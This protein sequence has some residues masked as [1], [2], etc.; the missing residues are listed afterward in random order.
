[1]Y[2]TSRYFLAFF[3]LFIIV[4]PEARDTGWY[5]VKW[6]GST[7]CILVPTSMVEFCTKPSNW[8][9]STLV[10]YGVPRTRCLGSILQSVV[11]SKGSQHG[12]IQVSCLNIF[13]SRFSITLVLLSIFS[14]S[15][16]ERRT[17]CQLYRFVHHYS[18]VLRICLIAEHLRMGHHPKMG[19]SHLVLA[20][21]LAYSKSSC[22]FKCQD[23]VGVTHQYW[24]LVQCMSRLVR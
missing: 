4:L 19:P 20:S 3:F 21:R 2:P 16:M 24:Y 11:I 22:I 5:Q 7:L 1:M 17:W 18:S 13:L 9:C 14:V 23:N 12:I 6:D 10:Q 8:P 15:T